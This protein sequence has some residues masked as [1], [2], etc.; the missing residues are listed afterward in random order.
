MKNHTDV[1]FLKL[2]LLALGLGL[3]ACDVLV[4]D[5]LPRTGEDEAVLD[6]EGVNIQVRPEE[7]FLLDLHTV[8]NANTELQLSIV[9]DPEFGVAAIQNQRWLS[10]VANADFPGEDLVVIA[11]KRGEELL[12][13]DTIRITAPPAGACS[14]AAIP[15]TWVGKL[16]ETVLTYEL[17]LPVEPDSCFPFDPSRG[18]FEILTPP[19]KGTLQVVGSQFLYEPV[20][21]TAYTVR[22]VFQQCI[23][24]ECAAG[25][26]NIELKEDEPCRLTAVNDAKELRYSPD[27]VPANAVIDVLA[28][29]I[30][31]GNEVSISV[32]SGP[33]ASQ[34]YVQDGKI[35]LDVYEMPS[36][37]AQLVYLITDSATQDTSSATVQ[38]TFVKECEVAARPDTLTIAT[39]TLAQDSVDYFVNI[40]ENDVFCEIQQVDLRIL[41]APAFGSAEIDDMGIRYTTVPSVE[42]Q[43]FTDSLRYQICE[44]DVCSEAD[45][46]IQFE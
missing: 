16:S 23:D 45:V 7:Q 3:G 41:Q 36:A 25:I 33:T 8:V 20:D 13:Q 44:G 28:N 12:D 11:A 2:V 34:W 1:P 40:L 5:V 4:E 39:D 27:S 26:L 22:A 18:G 29:D 35:V 24:G 6:S 10:Y 46:L 31:C 37:S 42:L 19:E 21:S 15:F 38:L 9:Q 32:I 30:L 17:P 14:P 43:Q